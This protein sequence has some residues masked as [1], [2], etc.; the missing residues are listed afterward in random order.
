MAGFERGSSADDCHARAAVSVRGRHR[1]GHERDR[2][3]GGERVQ[4]GRGRLLRN[5][6]R[7]RRT[8]TGEHQDKG[9]GWDEHGQCYHGACQCLSIVIV[10]HFSHRVQVHPWRERLAT[11]VRF[12]PDIVLGM[13]R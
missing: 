10:V 7:Q 6:L 12:V 11:E 2:R 8:T 4:R 1:R 5:S 3:G 13:L 9:K